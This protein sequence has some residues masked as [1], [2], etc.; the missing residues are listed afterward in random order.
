[1]HTCLCLTPLCIYGTHS[2]WVCTLKFQYLNP[3]VVKEEA[4]Q[5]TLWSHKNTAYTRLNH[6]RWNKA[7]QADCAKWGI[8]HRYTHKTAYKLYTDLRGSARLQ[9]VAVHH[10]GFEFLFQYKVQFSRYHVLNSGESKV[11]TCGKAC[12]YIANSESF[13]TLHRA[14]YP[15]CFFA[16]CSDYIFL[17][18]HFH[19][20]VYIISYYIRIL[21]LH[22]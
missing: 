18:L 14:L 3:S 9:N 16:S 10:T 12:N 20:I 6:W 8:L 13:W 5:L 1:M 19:F 11:L 2:K 17:L 4:P 15:G 22:F 7:A 21:Y